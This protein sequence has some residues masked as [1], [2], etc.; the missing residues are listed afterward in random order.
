MIT[1][2][3]IQGFLALEH[4]L[5][6]VLLVCI[7]SAAV[8]THALG[9]SKEQVIDAVSQA[10]F[11]GSTRLAD[12]GVPDNGWRPRWATADATSRGVR[13]ALM[14]VT[15]STDSPSVLPA[16]TPGLQEARLEG[17]SAGLAAGLGSGMTERVPLPAWT[18]QLREFEASG[19]TLFSP[20]QAAKITAL[21]ADRS[22]LEATPVHEF[23]AVMVR[24]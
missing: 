23:M 18:E 21:F 22:R 1:A 7:A 15:R 6:R 10:W 14:T 5:D 11:D 2:H 9:G 13:H 12:R 17:K 4:D 24:A 19:A 3:Q 16:Q 20:V 8:S